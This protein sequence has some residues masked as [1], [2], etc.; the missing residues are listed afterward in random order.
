MPSQ[1]TFN[2]D[3]TLTLCIMARN[4]V[5]QVKEQLQRLALLE[6]KVLER[7]EI[8]IIDN[9]STDGTSTAVKPFEGVVPFTYISNTEH[10]S[11]DNSF[12][13]ALNSSIRTHSKYIW[14][15]DARNVVRVGYFEELLDLLENNESGLGLVYLALR[16]NASKPYVQ[17]ID[18]D[19]FLQ[20]EGIGIIEVSRNI[21]RTDLIRG[22]N[23][24]QFSAGSGIPA[25]PL[26]LHVALAAK[27]NVVFS[28]VVFENARI[29]Y[30]AEV[31]DP[32]RTYVKNL[33]SVYDHYEDVEGGNTL[34]PVTVMK[35]RSKICDF[36]LPTIMSLY[37]LR[38]KIEGVDSNVSRKIIKQ[39][40][41]LRPIGAMLRKCVSPVLWGRVF[42]AIFKV[43]RKV[44][45]IIAAGITILVCNTVMVKAY[46][47]F[48][49][50]LNGYLLRNRIKHLGKNALIEG[51][52]Y[53]DGN[54][55]ISIG[56]DFHCRPGMHL[57]CIST[58]NY[59]PRITIGDYV[60]LEEN[61]RIDAVRDVRI[62]NNVQ[63]GRNVYIVDYQRGKTNAEALRI[64]PQE[65]D[66]YT[67]GA[68]DIEDNVVVG[69]NAVILAGVKIG[70]GAVIAAGAVVTRSIPPGAV[71]KG[72]PA[73]VN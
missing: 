39:Y 11:H 30:A 52:V 65:R 70:K 26:F 33:I 62:G 64:V 50:S 13:F 67:R 35:L 53:T 56:S 34:S 3:K 72:V 19:D 25:V 41:G 63:I 14:L 49:N 36:M 4:N 31:D 44:I 57:E 43:L 6:P 51:P 27:Q 29:N 8:I 10:L 23:P 58:G 28:P 73:R 45:E 55:Y 2:L 17:Y 60:L 59:T 9:D 21:I 24:R 1:L 20:H 7:V 47:N 48:K 5:M 61:V 32:V 42:G 40:L 22:Y 54:K 37:V 68:V 18:A 69:P 38:R 15:L 12:T 46:T 66:I 71:A 16:A